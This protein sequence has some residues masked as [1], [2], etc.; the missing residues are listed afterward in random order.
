[1]AGVVRRYVYGTGD[2]LAF[3]VMTSLCKENYG[4]DEQPKELE[5]GDVHVQSYGCGVVLI[6][7]R[8]DE[9]KKL[10]VKKEAVDFYKTL[11]FN[12]E[13]VERKSGNVFIKDIHVSTV[14]LQVSGGEI[15]NKVKIDEALRKC[16]R[17]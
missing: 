11:S 8:D 13:K 15:E 6:K 4:T 1:M 10:L 17:N 5:S 3:D 2:Q 16:F 14:R 12:G 7:V 9:V